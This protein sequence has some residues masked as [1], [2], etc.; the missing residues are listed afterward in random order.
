MANDIFKTVDNL[1]KGINDLQS[2]LAGL[3]KTFGRAVRR[4]VQGRSS[5]TRSAVR[6]AV[7]RVRKTS[8][9]QVKAMQKL[10]GRYMGLVRNLSEAQKAQVKKLKQSKGY[11]AAFELAARMRKS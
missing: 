7:S 10:Q 4:E 8:S 3:Q 2:Q 6:K 9:A 11:K 5:K 1:R